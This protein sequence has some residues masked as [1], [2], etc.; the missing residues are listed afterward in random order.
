MNLKI[1]FLFQIF[2]LFALTP[3]VSQEQ[4]DQSA[5]ELLSLY[6]DNIFGNDDRLISGHFYYGP[7]KGSIKGHPY[8]FDESWKN[9][10]IETA[11]ASFDGLQVKYDVCL[12][13]MILKYTSTDNAVYQIGLNPGNIISMKVANSEFIQ[14]P[15]TNDSIDAPFAEVISN[16]PVQYLVTKE[17]SL[18]ITSRPGSFDYEYKEYVKQYLFYS[19]MLIPFRN[20]K[21]LYKTFPEIKNQLKRYVRRN[22]LYLIRNR[23]DDRGKLI[24][25]CNTL[26][27]GNNE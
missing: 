25:Y 5:T 10:I 16:G 1:S 15:A 11:D 24:D 17:K 19:G 3:V 9:S 22:N 2:S 21:T 7:A 6:F 23:I 14:L 26:L 20:K 18:E 4:G 12:N 8:Y 27:S 13:R